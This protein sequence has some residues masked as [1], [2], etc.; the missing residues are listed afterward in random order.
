[1][2]LRVSYNDPDT[3]ER[4]TKNCFDFYYETND[5]KIE[6]TPVDDPPTVYKSFVVYRPLIDISYNQYGFRLMADGFCII[7]GQYD[8]NLVVIETNNDPK[9]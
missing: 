7:K 8:R 6:F 3:G 1:M 9:S 2:N 5:N 4:L